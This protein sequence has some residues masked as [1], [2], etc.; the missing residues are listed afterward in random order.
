MNY[1]L[2]TIAFLVAAGASYA[3]G[4]AGGMFALLAIGLVFEGIFW[5]RLIRERRDTE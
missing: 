2:I 3:G 1:H 5:I 4:L